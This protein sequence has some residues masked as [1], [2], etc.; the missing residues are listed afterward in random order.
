MNDGNDK[1]MRRRG[2]YFNRQKEYI[3]GLDGLRAI[4]VLMVFA[5]H[6]RMPFAKGGLL[7]VTVFFVLSGFLITR[8]LVSELEENNTIDLAKFW[9]RRIRR[10]LPAILVMVTAL[11][12]VSAVFNRVLFTKFCADLPSAIFCY[13]NW[14]QI[15]NHISYFENVGAPSPL[16]HCWSLAIEA[17]FYLVY[18]LVL[19]FLKRFPSPTSPAEQG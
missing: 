6:L 7:G 15:F 16:T 17:Q 1:H 3:A 18:P 11:T 5:Y 9:V 8:I 19:I 12:F 2:K 10:L 4:A 13:N 14:W